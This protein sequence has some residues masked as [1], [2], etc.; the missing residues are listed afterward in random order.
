VTRS[1]LLSAAKANTLLAAAQ[2]FRPVMIQTK[3]TNTA[4]RKR[5]KK[6]LLGYTAAQRK[7]PGYKANYYIVS[8]EPEP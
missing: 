4:M 2:S 3:P 1:N 7:G 6:K 5:E 8:P